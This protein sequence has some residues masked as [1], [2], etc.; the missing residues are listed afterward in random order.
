MSIQNK[1]FGTKDLAP[2]TT[3]SLSQEAQRRQRQRSLAIAWALGALTVIFFVATIA[4]IGS[5]TI[6]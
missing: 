2:S 3:T 6:N 1:T 4:R 5:H